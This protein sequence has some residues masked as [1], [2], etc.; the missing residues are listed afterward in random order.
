MPAARALIAV[1]FVLLAACGSGSK[2]PP[3]LVLAK[4][5]LTA[6]HERLAAARTQLARQPGAAFRIAILVEPFGSQLNANVQ[7]FFNNHADELY[8]CIADDEAAAELDVLYRYDAAGRTALA[9]FDASFAR[10][11]AAERC[12]AAIIADGPLARPRSD[13]TLA[14]VPSA[15]VAH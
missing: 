3:G 12:M 14:F 11:A 5:D 2:A 7:S 9:V 4:G 1:S 10:R 13:G 15:L 8:A 6:A